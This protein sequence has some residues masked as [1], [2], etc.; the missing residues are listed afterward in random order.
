MAKK[1][2]VSSPAPKHEKLPFPHGASLADKREIPTAETPTAPAEPDY[3]KLKLQAVEDLVTA[4]PENSPPVSRQELRKYHAG[5]KVHVADWV[6][7]ILLKVWFAG[8]I[9]YFFIWGLSTLALNQWDLIFILGVVLG[10]ATH[11]LTNNIYRFTAKQEGAYDRWMMF[12]GKSLAFLPADILYAMVLILCTIMTYN[13]INLLLAG[14]DS[15]APALGVEP[16]LF[17]VITT[18]WDLLFLGAKQLCMR[19]LFDAKQK[20]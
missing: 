14:P 3:Y 18:L 2:K 13:G 17:G 4:N 20:A 16:I 6:K 19:I 12:P 9:C 1:K 15:A 8:V 7:A 11:L 10:G 5:P